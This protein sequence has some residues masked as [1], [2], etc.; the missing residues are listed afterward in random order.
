M[1]CESGHG[2]RLIV[3]M[4][5]EIAT[6][7]VQCGKHLHNPQGVH[8]CIHPRDTVGGSFY[9]CIEFKVINAEP[10]GTFMA[11]KTKGLAHSDSFRGPPSMLPAFLIFLIFFAT[12]SILFRPV[13]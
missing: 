1:G 13:I 8:A 6:V 9:P 5:L 2:P 12:I 3:H 11:T 7:G 4:H 10:Y